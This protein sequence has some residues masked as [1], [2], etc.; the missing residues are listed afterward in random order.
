MSEFEGKAEN[1]YRIELFRF[2]PLTDLGSGS[3]DA[4]VDLAAKR[5]EINGLC[6]ERLGTTFQSFSLGISVTIGGYHDDWDVRSCC[7]G[8]RQ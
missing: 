4:V 3:C 6:Q 8:L 7:L 1:I 2:G 5:N